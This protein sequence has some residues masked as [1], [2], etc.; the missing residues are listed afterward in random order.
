MGGRGAL[1]EIP[2]DTVTDSA[3]GLAFWY[4]LSTMADP[5]TPYQD[6]PDVRRTP[7]APYRDPISSAQDSLEARALVRRC[8]VQRVLTADVVIQALGNGEHDRLM[9]N[10]NGHGRIRLNGDSKAGKWPWLD[11]DQGFLASMRDPANYSQ[12]RKIT[13]WGLAAGILVLLLLVSSWKTVPP[14]FSS[15]DYGPCKRD[16]A[17][18]CGFITFVLS[19]QHSVQC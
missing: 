7:P 11:I 2:R 9:S 5:L 14:G 12:R 16:K 1:S 17:F 13:L 4:S 15:K 18:E 8:R 3:S 6:T 19:L 10:G